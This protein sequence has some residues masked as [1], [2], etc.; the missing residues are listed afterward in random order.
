[1]KKRR[2]GRP[3]DKRT[4]KFLTNRQIAARRSAR[5]GGKKR[6]APK[7][8]K[9]NPVAKK[10]RR[11]RRRGNPGY[12]KKRLYVAGA[13]AAYGY[14]MKQ[15]TVAENVPVIAGLGRD[16]TNAIAL[17]FLAKHFKSKWLDYAATAVAG[18]VGCELGEANFKLEELATMSGGDVS[19][20]IDAEDE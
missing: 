3:R 2:R 16:A 14:L 9:G 17:H 19:G 18:H 15:T 10:K 12:G 6:K 8:R 1:M 20:Y 7:R 13:G 4:G 11:S 5:K